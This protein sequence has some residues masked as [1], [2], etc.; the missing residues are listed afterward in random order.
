MSSLSFSPHR[1]NNIDAINRWIL[2]KTVNFIAAAG[3]Q[4]ADDVTAVKESI[5]P[6]SVLKFTLKRGLKLIYFHTNN[7]YDRDGAGWNGED[8]PN[9]WDITASWKPNTFYL[10]E[11]ISPIAL[12]LFDPETNSLVR[13]FCQEQDFSKKSTSLFTGDFL[14]SDRSFVYLKNV[15]GIDK[16]VRLYFVTAYPYEFSQYPIGEVKGLQPNIGLFRASVSIVRE[17]FDK[18]F[19][20]VISGSKGVAAIPASY[21]KQTEEELS[22]EISVDRSD[23]V[24]GSSKLGAEFLAIVERMRNAFFE[25]IKPENEPG[26]SS[27]QYWKYYFTVSSIVRVPTPFVFTLVVPRKKEKP[28]KLIAPLYMQSSIIFAEDVLERINN[29]AR[30]AT[31]A[32]GSIKVSFGSSTQDARL[33]GFTAEQEIS[34]KVT[35]AGLTHIIREFV[36][37]GQNFAEYIPV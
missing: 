11:K 32:Q 1:Q 3:T 33:N 2:L 9:T 25:R 31:R 12:S 13:Q 14:P 5:I 22:E 19:S 36:T 7:Q 18:T 10:K 23:E 29:I 17:N 34:G 30:E 4:G 15:K 16:L 21:P 26:S 28:Y 35:A 24:T 8:M 20:S 6:G 37:F 27:E